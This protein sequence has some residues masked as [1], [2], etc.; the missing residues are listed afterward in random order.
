MDFGDATTLGLCLATLLLVAVALS[1]SPVLRVIRM[2]RIERLL[3]WAYWPLLHALDQ[4]HSRHKEPP[5]N[6]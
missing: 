6:G 1:I 2:R 5:R 4:R 3:G